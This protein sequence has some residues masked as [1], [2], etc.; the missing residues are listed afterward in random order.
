LKKGP[1]VTMNHANNSSKQSMKYFILVATFLFISEPFYSQ[2]KTGAIQLFDPVHLNDFAPADK[3]FYKGSDNTSMAQ[4]AQSRNPKLFEVSHQPDT[5]NT[6]RYVA[7]SMLGN[8]I[9]FGPYNSIADQLDAFRQLVK[10]MN[11]IRSA[12]AT[13]ANF[14]RVTAVTVAAGQT[15]GDHVSDVIG[16]GV[17]FSVD[18][19]AE[20]EAQIEQQRI[21]E[22]IKEFDPNNLKIP[23]PASPDWEQRASQMVGRMLSGES[24]EKIGKLQ[25]KYDPN[26][27]GKDGNGL[28]GL[29]PVTKAFDQWFATLMDIGINL[30]DQFLCANQCR[31]ITEKALMLAYMIMPGEM[32]R[33]VSGLAEIQDGLVSDDIDETLNKIT[34]TVGVLNSMYNDIR[35]FK[36]LLQNPNFQNLLENTDVKSALDALGKLG[37]PTDKFKEACNFLP[38]N[39]FTPNITEKDFLAAITKWGKEKAIDA[40]VDQLKKSIGNQPF[41]VDLDAFKGLLNDGDMKKFSKAQATSMVCNNLKQYGPDCEKLVGG[42]HKVAIKSAIARSISEGS[43]LNKEQ[44]E[45]IVNGLQEGDAKKILTNA[46]KM[47]GKTIL[48]K[49]GVS[50][51]SINEWVTDPQRFNQKIEN[52]VKNLVETS[53]NDEQV[54]RMLRAHYKIQVNKTDSSL[55]KKALDSVGMQFGLEIN[56]ILD[57]S[58]EKSMQ[59]MIVNFSKALGITKAKAIELLKQ[60]EYQKAIEAQLGFAQEAS[61]GWSPKIHPITII[62]TNEELYKTLYKEF[63]KHIIGEEYKKSLIE[64]YKKNYVQL[65]KN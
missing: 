63:G 33:I 57:T 35:K 64:S 51:D 52:A 32:D 56:K 20:K 30:L 27:T 61:S 48:Q 34:H 42:D 58:F 19:M 59:D 23:D 12:G 53:T 46:A 24:Q 18:Q 7:Y 13:D 36:D 28:K 29:F 43:G 10:L 49:F 1:N 21:I 25:E 17:T 15:F 3:N 5:K 40:G 54:K 60:K 2:E 4:W 45:G 9:W 22:E 55:F 11:S 62:R 16:N 8:G 47:P 50:K 31:G 44:I 39:G 37:V 38:C 26:G 41:G 6:T 14:V 65:I